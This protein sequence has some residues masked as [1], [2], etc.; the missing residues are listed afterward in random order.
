MG[1][2]PKWGLKKEVLS[3]LRFADTLRNFGIN[4]DAL[5][6]K[7]SDFY[8]FHSPR[9]VFLFPQ[10]L[11][12]LDYLKQKYHLHIITN[13]FEEVQRTKLDVSGLREYFDT[14]ITS[15]EAGV[16]KPDR[17]IFDFALKRTR[18]LPTESI[19]IGDDLEV[20]ILG[21]MDA[22]IEGVYFNP[23]A[24]PHDEKVLFEIKM[25]GELQ[26]YF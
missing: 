14:V 23:E 18:A 8:L 22:G 9:N 24:K 16:K 4:D 17:G 11:E 7:L 21:A 26:N 12:T 13:G 15:E 10:A 1:I 3:S 2:I 25:L 19:M 20:D 6:E 5:A